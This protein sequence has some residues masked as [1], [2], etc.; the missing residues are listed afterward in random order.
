MGGANARLTPRSPSSPSAAAAA[1]AGGDEP[2]ELAPRPTRELVTRVMH[3][4]FNVNIDWTHNPDHIAHNLIDGVPNAIPWL[5][6]GSDPTADLTWIM[7]FWNSDKQTYGYGAYTYVG[8]LK[9]D[10][11][12]AK[13]IYDA[14]RLVDTNELS[15]ENKQH[16]LAAR[17]L[18]KSLAAEMYEGVPHIF[19]GPVLAWA[20]VMGKGFRDADGWPMPEMTGWSDIGR[21]FVSA[22]SLLLRK[23]AVPI[24]RDPPPIIDMMP[25]TLEERNRRLLLTAWSKY[26]LRER[27]QVPAPFAYTMYEPE[28]SKLE[29]H[30]A[31]ARADILDLLSGIDTPSSWTDGLNGLETPTFFVNLTFGQLLV[32]ESGYNSNCPDERLLS[33]FKIGVNWDKDGWKFHSCGK[34]AP[35]FVSLWRRHL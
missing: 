4:S 6:P 20:Y 5:Q 33:F 29:L 21:D 14:L 34:K 26:P 12:K 15:A 19:V 16:C 2:R 35:D 30:C 18:A 9:E 24:V 32:V 17:M 10:Q 25:A 28:I 31:T 13:R 1:A 23:A 11:E 27:G 7:L 3:D 22:V 8:W